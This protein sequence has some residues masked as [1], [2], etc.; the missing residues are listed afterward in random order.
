MATVIERQRQQLQRQRPLYERIQDWIF[1]W[2]IGTGAQFFRIGIF[3]VLLVGVV[4]VYTGTQFFGLRDPEAMNTAQLARNLALGRGY[5]TRLIRPLDLFYLGSIGKPT[6]NPQRM[7]VPELWT[8]PGYA[9][10]LAVP[11][12]FVGARTDHS[13]IAALR[14][15]RVVM[16]TG[17]FFFATG[18]VVMYLLAREL[19]DRRVAALSAFLY[20]FCQGLLDHAMSGLAT[21]FV[22][23]LLLVAAYAL[24]K[25]DRWR[26]A[27]RTDF[28][29][30]AALAVSV[31]AVGLATLAQYVVCVVMVPLLVY[32]GTVFR[33]RRWLRLLLCLAV[34]ALVLAPWMLRN[35]HASR[36]WFGL[37]HHGLLEETGRNRARKPV[38]HYQ[39]GYAVESP[40]Q[41]HALAVKVLKNSRRLYEV[42]IKE[43]GANYL[44]AFF[45]VSLI[46]RWRDDEAV[47]LRRWL[48][49]AMIGCA[50]WL[51][52]AGVPQRNFFTA[53]APLVIVYA[54]AFFVVLFERLQFRK[55]FLRKGFV[56]L[57]VL[58]NMAPMIW[59]V[60]PPRETFPYPPY[61]SGVGAELG[62]IFRADELLASD[63]PWAV[64]WYGD[65]SALWMPPR[66]RD[67]IEINDRVRLVTGVYLTQE[68]LEQKKVLEEWLGQDHFILRLFQPPP[69]EGFPLRVY[70]AMTPDGEQVL[71]SNRSR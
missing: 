25:A 6:L 71:L 34:F 55:R 43:T 67:F 38:G 26:R 68:T 32:V 12:R 2:D 37:A 17:W 62:R 48:L 28:S 22:A 59:A 66:E 27:E 9:L 47:R 61:N 70:R 46:H 51:S 23:T 54:A 16:L 64:A 10:A 18:L 60:L 65:R 4:L 57:F 53:F 63:I 58:L 40:W 39:R 42:T 41:W 36:K 44:I 19:F 24:F 35:R 5:T 1:A 21:G 13:N 8:P 33:E 45:L 69:P 15:D 56:G 3:A 31:L 50:G 30:N 52:V 11:L 14:A 7:T 29:V 20:L 49:W